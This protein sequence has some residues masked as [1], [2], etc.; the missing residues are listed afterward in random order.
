MFQ[1]M[2]YMTCETR[3]KGREKYRIGGPHVKVTKSETKTSL[4]NAYPTRQNR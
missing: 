3:L 1:N 4:P 2:T